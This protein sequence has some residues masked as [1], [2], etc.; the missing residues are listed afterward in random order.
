MRYTGG[1]VHRGEGTRGGGYTGGR[2][3]G[4][5]RGAAASESPDGAEFENRT[6]SRR[7]DGSLSPAAPDPGNDG[8]E[9]SWEPDV[10]QLQLL[11]AAQ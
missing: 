11:F 3:T 5:R 6:R 8:W 7:S 10:E 4:G 9:L 2:Y 1:R